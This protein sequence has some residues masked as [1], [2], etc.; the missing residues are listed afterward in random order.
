MEEEKQNNREEQ[1]KK[2]RF[3]IFG[4]PVAEIGEL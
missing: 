1:I 4:D 2:K 3:T